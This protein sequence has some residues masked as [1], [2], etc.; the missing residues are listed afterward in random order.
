MSALTK[1]RMG[2]LLAKIKLGRVFTMDWEKDPNPENW[3]TINGSHVHL[4][5]GKI[6]GGAGG[7]FAGN[8]WVG[9]KMHASDPR[10]QQGT[11]FGG[12]KYG[13]AV[14]ES[15][16]EK[17]ARETAQANK[18]SI[19]SLS[20]EIA[21]LKN[22]PDRFNWED[23]NAQ[24][25]IVSQLSAKYG[26]V[27]KLLKKLPEGS[28]EHKQALSL[29]GYTAEDWEEV[30]KD[31]AKEAEREKKR[32]SEKEKA[33]KA[34]MAENEAAAK[35][36]GASNNTPK[37]VE[38]ISQ[39]IGGEPSRHAEVTKKMS[40]S[41]GEQRA[42]EWFEKEENNRLG[43]DM[44]G[45]SRE[46]DIRNTYNRAIEYRN[47]LTAIA[48]SVNSEIDRINRKRKPTKEDEA[49]LKQL[50]TKRMNAENA[51]TAFRAELEK[52]KQKYG[53]S[54]QYGAGIGFKVDPK[55]G[56][57]VRST[58]KPLPGQARET[59]VTVGNVSGQQPEEKQYY[60][61]LEAVAKL[62]EMRKAKKAANKP[63]TEKP[64]STAP[65]KKGNAR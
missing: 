27:E 35:Q 33:W 12:G 4:E 17:Q 62:R 51:D 19:K 18:S 8:D 6:N 56:E 22:H 9:K 54:E 10:V 16:S 52:F 21:R 63:A 40:M 36:K 3:R 5:N 29:L 39:E 43:M 44:P 45:Y 25:K 7:K 61:P 30:K 14:P 38:A 58:A 37:R 1:I 23:S 49:T 31:I 41:R 2:L 15:K 50:N 34:A 59:T 24:R 28:A 60:S 57:M 48:A 13:W 26:E 55:T 47:R 46:D 53:I 20:A 42:K 64:K 65:K 32:F 11:L